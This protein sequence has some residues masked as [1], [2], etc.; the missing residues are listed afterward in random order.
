M[1]TNTSS[2]EALANAPQS[3]LGHRK[4]RVA[5]LILAATI[6][7]AAAFVA[8]GHWLEGRNKENRRTAETTLRKARSDVVDF[9][10][11]QENAA[12][13]KQVFIA[14]ANRGAFQAEDRQSL[15]ERIAALKEKHGLVR[16]AFTLSQQTAAPYTDPSAIQNIKPRASRLAIE[17]T[18]I[19]EDRLLEFAQALPAQV[20][21][22][23]RPQR[24]ELTKL[25]GRP[26]RGLQATD[27]ATVSLNCVYEWITVQGAAPELMA[28]VK[29]EQ[30]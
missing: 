19:H 7:A 15:V 29:A 9:R 13:S 26:S 4:L 25:A 22:L 1:S 28:S 3:A 23:L 20:L 6:I 2:S 18:A 11:R 24:C 17:A 14:L 30:R 10:S 8:F 27:S 16:A 5:W 12:V 21:G